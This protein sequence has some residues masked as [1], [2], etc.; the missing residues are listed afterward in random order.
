VE[1]FPEDVLPVPELHEI[2]PIMKIAEIKIKFF[3]FFKLK[4]YN[5]KY[6]RCKIKNNNFHE[7]GTNVTQV[8]DSQTEF[9]I[10]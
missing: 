4:V 6:N 8:C 9:V 5:T 10:A 1:S 2:N 3:I 7:P